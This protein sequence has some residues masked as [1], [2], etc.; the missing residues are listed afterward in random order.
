MAGIIA[1]DPSGLANSTTYYFKVN[2]VQYS[3][4]TGVSPTFQDVANLMDVALD[5]AGFSVTIVG[6]APNQ[7]LR[8]RNV[9]V[10]GIGSTC[11]LSPGTTSPDL[12]SN[13]NFWSRFRLPMVNTYN[14]LDLT[15]T[16]LSGKI[17]MGGHALNQFGEGPGVQWGIKSDLSIHS[18]WPDAAQWIGGGYSL[19]SVPPGK[20]LRSVSMRIYSC[21]APIR[22]AV[23]QWPGSGDVYY[24]DGWGLLYD[25]GTIPAV[26]APGGWYT[27]SIP[28]GS[29]PPFPFW[30]YLIAFKTN[31]FS[32]IYVTQNTAEIEDFDSAHGIWIDGFDTVDSDPLVAWPSSVPVSGTISEPVPQHWVNIYL[33]YGDP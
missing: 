27:K 10:R 17:T 28:G 21:P 12:F 26:T 30:I 5:S 6:T 9:N 22:F 7:D 14:T 3:I 15:A 31:V 25:L 13:L 20:A 23:Y 33:T 1:T 18:P 32:D 29:R 4:I 8:I 16:V 11:N 19:L 2:N 24:P